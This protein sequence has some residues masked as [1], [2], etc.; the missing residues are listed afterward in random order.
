MAERKKGD[1]FFKFY[2][3]PSKEDEGTLKD[4]FELT[5]IDAEASKKNILDYLDKK[6]AETR[7]EM[8]KEF[9]ERY[10]SIIKEQN[11][12]DIKDENIEY[13]RAGRK[14]KDNIENTGTDEEKKKLNI[15]RKLKDEND[16]TSG[17]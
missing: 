5:G 3:D 4:Y 17:S 1:N 15:I 11:I 12:E 9:K 2:L 13:Q 14:A 8:G 16:K 7:I 10:E 6:E